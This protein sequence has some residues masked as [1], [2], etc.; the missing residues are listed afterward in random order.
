[1]AGTSPPVRGSLVKKYKALFGIIFV[2]L[3][4]LSS[5]SIIPI[6]VIIVHPDHISREASPVIDICFVIRH[7][8]HDEIIIE[9]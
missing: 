9:A 6:R 2:F 8:A 7:P 5:R 1:M 3:D 4:D